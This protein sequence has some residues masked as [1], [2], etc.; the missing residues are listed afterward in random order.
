MTLLEII[1]DIE[2]FDHG[3]IIRATKPWTEISE[4]IVVEPEVREH[5]AKAERLGMDFFLEV[6][7]ARSLLEYGA[8]YLDAKQTHEQKCAALIEYACKSEA[9][10]SIVSSLASGC[11]QE[12]FSKFK[13][14][15]CGNDLSLSFHPKRDLFHLRCKQSSRHLST[16]QEVEHWVDWWDKF[17]TDGWY[18][19]T[20]QSAQ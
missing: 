4:A 8:R 18:S 3:G 20:R 6:S 5:P 1:R 2:T 16:H 19:E 10:K 15:V 7:T 13:C 17:I 9:I 11:T 12:E 14:P